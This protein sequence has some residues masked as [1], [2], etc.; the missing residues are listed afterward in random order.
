MGGGMELSLCFL[1]VL[2]NL[3]EIALGHACDGVSSSTG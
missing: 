1:L 2:G 3:S